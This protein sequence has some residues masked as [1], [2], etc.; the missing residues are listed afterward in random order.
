M[1]DADPVRRLWTKPGTCYFGRFAKM[2]W[3]EGGRYHGMARDPGDMETNFEVRSFDS[4]LSSQEYR[5]LPKH[6]LT[7]VLDNLRSAFNVGSIFRLADTMRVHRLILC[8]YTAHPP[9]RKLEK[10][11]LG[12]IDFVPWQHYERTIDAV[13]NLKQS[14]IPVWAAETTS[15]S[16]RYDSISYPS[17]LAIVF[18]NE[19]LGVDRSVLDMCDRMIEIPTYGFKNS[20][21]VATSVSVIGYKFL[22]KA[23]EQ[24][25]EGG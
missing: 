2:F 3:G 4:P 11:S 1:G 19:A 6:P 14:G 7:I 12:T 22:E 17:E 25:R 23:V 9:H 21:N 16:V 20:L 18:G 24:P 13:R 15:H 10:T 5:A 8:G